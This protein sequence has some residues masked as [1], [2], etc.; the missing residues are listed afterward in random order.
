MDGALK[1]PRTKGQTMNTIDIKPGANLRD[2][3]LRGADLR[4]AFLTNADTTGARF[5]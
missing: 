4:G 2:A 5:Y 3:D 1:P